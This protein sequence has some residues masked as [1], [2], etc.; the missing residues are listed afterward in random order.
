LSPEEAA[1]KKDEIAIAADEE[2]L[3]DEELLANTEAANG[4]GAAQ[5]DA[6]NFSIGSIENDLKMRLEE[7]FTL[8]LEAIGLKACKELEKN[9][10]VLRNK[11][12]MKLP[13]M[14]AE[15]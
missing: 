15:D 11:E 10:E 2:R 3:R 5:S 8:D 14:T 12:L 9:L 1:R 4:G 13:N 7:I 6:L